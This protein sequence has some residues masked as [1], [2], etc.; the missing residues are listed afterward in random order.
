MTIVRGGRLKSG[1]VHVRYVVMV[2]MCCGIIR[3]HAY[4]ALRKSMDFV[5]SVFRVIPF[6]PACAAEMV[7]M[8]KN[9]F[10]LVN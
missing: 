10:F 5:Q 8:N 4:N 7:L 3:L 9:N 6:V 1:R 2:Q